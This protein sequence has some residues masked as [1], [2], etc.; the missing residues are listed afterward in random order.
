MRDVPDHPSDP[1]LP[2]LFLKFFAS[3][4]LCLFRPKRA[5]LVDREAVQSDPI[6]GFKMGWHDR[7]RLKVCCTLEN[8]IFLFGIRFAAQRAFDLMAFDLLIPIRSIIH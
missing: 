2:C 1:C 7:H 8:R 5:H 3:L 4:R 6:I